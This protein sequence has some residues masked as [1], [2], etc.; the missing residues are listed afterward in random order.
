[1]TWY[2]I[3]NVYHDE[4]NLLMS[5]IKT[6]V[7]YQNDLFELKVYKVEFIDYVD[8]YLETNNC[9][10]IERFGVLFPTKCEKPGFHIGE[11]IFSS[12]I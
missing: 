11:S 12:F 1:M 5:V 9:L 8:V 2:K 10:F 6:H 4:F 7:Y 3:S